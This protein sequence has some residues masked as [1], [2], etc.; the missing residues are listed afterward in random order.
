MA[1]F[2]HPPCSSQPKT[3]NFDI[4]LNFIL[5]ALIV[6]DCPQFSSSIICRLVEG[7][8]VHG[9]YVIYDYSRQGRGH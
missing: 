4:G 5:S 7:A 2:P 6:M 8:E 9:I 1:Q 3:V